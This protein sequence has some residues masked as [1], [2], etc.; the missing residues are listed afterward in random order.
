MKSRLILPQ[1]KQPSEG[2]LNPIHVLRKNGKGLK[3]DPS[4]RKPKSVID[5]ELMPGERLILKNLSCS[6]W[7]IRSVRR[8]KSHSRCW[9]NAYVVSLLKF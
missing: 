6:G 8:M 7:R 3:P 1:N 4:K 2:E 9:A 5:D